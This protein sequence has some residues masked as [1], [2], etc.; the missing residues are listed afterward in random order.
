M[1]GNTIT[2]PQ[3]LLEAFKI[4]LASDNDATGDITNYRYIIYARKSTESEERQVRS[5]SDQTLEC[6]DLANKNNLIVS[7]V[8]KESESAKEPDIRPKFREMLQDLNKGKYDGIIAWHPDR[9]ARNMKDAGEIIDLLDKKII[10]DLKF[11]S[12]TF[13]NNT[14]GKMLLGIAFVL[15]KQYSD[16]L[17]D[18]VKRGNKRSTEEGKYLNRAKH[19]YFKDRNQFLRPDGKN[20][21]L[22]KSAFRMRAEG[23]ALDEI[24]NYLNEHNYTRAPYN[25]S[26]QRQHKFTKQTISVILKDPFYMG[27][28]KYGKIIVNLNEIYD[29]VPMI[30]TEEFLKINH[31]SDLTKALRLSAKYFKDDSVKA[32]LLRGMVFCGECGESMISGITNKKSGSKIISYYYYRCDNPEC[33][34]RGKS[35]RAHIITNFIYDFLENNKFAS[36][37]TY[38]SYVK[39]MQRIIAEREKSTEKEIRSFSQ[40]KKQKEKKFEQIKNLILNEKDEET[41]GYFKGDLKACE[42]QIN[43]LNKKIDELKEL[44]NKN[45]SA[46]MTLTEYLELFDNL[47]KFMKKIKRMDDLDYIIKKIFLNFT[48]RDGKISNFTINSPFR[49]FIK[50]DFVLTSRGDRT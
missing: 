5:L 11:V 3:D 28:L 2:T 10:R 38:N 29:F 4:G 35:N 42:S 33:K 32:N 41:I 13:E 19:G 8:I 18:T 27:I 12:F 22:I 15:S 21:Q 40:S 14:M 7:K 25:E 6:Q 47:P 1:S 23:K 9:L 48:I 36:K 45:G 24:A 34:R 43:D 37:E 30:T 31:Y 16:Q 20:F 46:I 39:E 17:S 49:E 26:P 44:K 50:P